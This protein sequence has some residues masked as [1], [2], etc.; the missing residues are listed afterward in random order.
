MDAYGLSGL[1]CETTAYG[2]IIIS[3]KSFRE[4]ISAVAEDER[5]AWYLPNIE[6]NW[7]YRNGRIS[8]TFCDENGDTDGRE[9]LCGQCAERIICEGNADEFYF[10]SEIVSSSDNEW[11]CE[12]G[13]D[14]NN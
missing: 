10:F 2:H 6:S 3:C 1:Q 9:A 14:L 8:Y 11:F 12:C 4:A 5:D 7:A 13:Y